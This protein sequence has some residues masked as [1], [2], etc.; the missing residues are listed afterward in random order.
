M[1]IDLRDALRTTA[2]TAPPVRVPTGLFDRARRARARRRALAAIATA[3]IVA[4]VVAL[5][6]VPRTVAPA[7]PPESYALPSRVVA[8]PA[9]TAD[10]RDAGLPRA[11]VV[12]HRENL[13][14][15]S[16]LEDAEPLAVV[17][18]ANQYRVYDRPTW[19]PATTTSPSFLLSPDGRYLLMPNSHDG[20]DKTLITDLQTGETRVSLDGTIAVAWTSDS[21]HVV[22][23]SHWVDNKTGWDRVFIADALTGARVWQPPSTRNDS[24]SGVRDV[25]VAVSPAGDRTAY[26]HDTTVSI[27]DMASL[28]ARTFDLAGAVIAGGQAFTPA[29]DLVAQLPN[30]NLEVISATN[31]RVTG[32]LATYT[33]PT[34]AGIPP[35]VTVVGWIGDTPVVSAADRVVVLSSTPRVLVQG[36]AGTDELQVA[37]FAL[38]QPTVRAGTPDPGPWLDRYRRWIP[39]RVLGLIGL[40]VVA[41]AAFAGVRIR[42]R[43]RLR[44]RS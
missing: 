11:L 21:R 42:R 34:I 8:P 9:H 40:G 38:G 36:P 20:N 1:T 30:G 10:I 43:I 22:A 35:T 23:L 31:G 39:A 26:Q 2:E 24:M 14:G 37:T 5:P 29:G 33:F 28:D 27:N 6:A 18:A 25:E 3:L 7:D 44:P 15:A 17:G 4:A 16:W 41:I 12:Y 32:H 13:P 19:E